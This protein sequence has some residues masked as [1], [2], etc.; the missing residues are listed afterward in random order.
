MNVLLIATIKAVGIFSKAIITF[1]GEEQLWKYLE[2]LV[3]VSEVKI[4]K[5][6]EQQDDPK[7]DFK[8]FKQILK[9]QK[10]LLS[11]IE[12]YS[13]ILANLKSQ[14]PSEAF[15]L[16]FFKVCAIGVRHHRKLY[17]KYRDRLYAALAHFTMS[18]A[19]HKAP[20]M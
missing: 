1:M 20:F 19:S 14:A 2:K 4:I 11:F 12:S 16:H 5:E 13:F 15:L 9:K 7:N 10:Q 18:L 3:E 6:F 17:P 8:N